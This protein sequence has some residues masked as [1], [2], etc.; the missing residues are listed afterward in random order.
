MRRL[1]WHV[2]LTAIGLVGVVWA[3]TVAA[4]P[5]ITCRDVVMR[6]GDVCANAEGTRSQTWEERSA[7]AQQARPV[8]G[9]MGL[10]VAGFGVALA[11]QDVRAGRGTA[12]PQG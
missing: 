6:P 10:V 4:N 7:A 11:V 8:I 12:T 5:V 1:W 9:V 3:L 2:A